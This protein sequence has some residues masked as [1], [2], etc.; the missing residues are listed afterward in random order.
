MLMRYPD[1]PLCEGGLLLRRWSRGDVDDA[2]RCCND[3]QIRRYLP[4]IPIPYTAADAVAFIEAEPRRLMAGSVTLVMAS[5]DDRRLQGALGIRQVEPGVAQI[6]YWTD[7]GVRG[8]GIAGA[9]LILVSRWAIGTLGAGRVQLHTALD[10]VASMRV[11]E[12]AGFTRE[13]VL[14]RWYDLRGERRDAVMYSLLP[15]DVDDAAA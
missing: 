9:A 1:P 10:N 5:A 6:G 2:V 4:A 11:A 12:R 8:R 14:R 15:R 13:G 7:P 3:E